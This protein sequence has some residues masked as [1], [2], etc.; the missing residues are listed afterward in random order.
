MLSGE[1]LD[2]KL[3]PAF[4]QL[5]PFE[6]KSA[7]NSLLDKINSPEDISKCLA[8]FEMFDAQENKTI[9][10]KLLFKELSNAQ[11]NKIPVIC[12]L[13]ERYV[14]KSEIVNKFWEMLKNSSLNSDVKITIINLLRELDSD[15]SYQNAEEILGEESSQILDENTK[16]LL[17]NAIIN[18]EVQID[19]MDFLATIKVQ[20]KITLLNS[21]ENDFSQDALANILIPV[22][23]SEPNSPQGLE[24]LRI[25]GQTK[26][27]LALHVLEKVNKVAK[28]ELSQNIRKSLATLKMSG[29]REDNT[30]E[31]YK[32]ILSNTIPDK[33]Y[34]TYPDA[35]SDMAMIFTR[36]TQNDKIRFV[37]IVINLESGIKDC[38]GFFEI[39]QFECSKILERFLKDDRTADISPEDFKTILYNAE[40]S[41]I[42][43]KNGWRLPYEYVCWKNLLLDVDFE[44]KPI[45]QILKEQIIPENIDD[46]IFEKLDKM[47]V[48]TRWF[49]DEHYS[50]EFES[51]IKTLAT[52]NNLD[53]VVEDYTEI[54]FY[55]QEKSSWMKKLYMSAFIKYSIGKIEE[56]I[57]IYSLLFSENILNGFFKNVL[58]RS[59]YEYFM[60][61]KYNKDLNVNNF[62]PEQIDEKIKFIEEKWVK[63]V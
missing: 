53:K 49:L 56:S 25:L 6:I 18:P 47:K 28:G 15:W 44:A 2:N 36:K 50:S 37:S 43:D 61:I 29:I 38:F 17:D 5:N 11:K 31:F 20:D 35:H 30:K 63:S 3:S 62:S 4:K 55:P 14:E 12:F 57:Q 7:L 54:V 40:L 27:Q 51:L 16:Q 8:D 34:V 48:S 1:R 59:I 45:E 42:N 21:F 46:S 58:K 39:S 32:K 23:E 24:A 19:F 33:F 52:N 41:T 10:S 22:F 60:T 26:S 9:L 13:L